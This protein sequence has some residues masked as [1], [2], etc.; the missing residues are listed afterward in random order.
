MK[1]DPISISD[2][3]A[4]LTIS[5]LNEFFDGKIIPNVGVRL[6]DGRRWPDDEPRPTTILL[7]H[8]GALRSMLLPGTEVG[9]G[10]A[11]LYDDFDVE[12]NLEG[13]FDLVDRL[14]LDLNGVLDKLRAGRNLLKLPSGTKHKPGQRGPA[15]LKGKSH[16]IERDRKAVTYHY[17]VSNQF[18]ALWLD[19]HM[20]YSCAYFQ[21]ENDDLDRAQEHKLDHICRKLRLRS[22]Q[23]LLDIGCGWGG[24]AIYAAQRYGVKAT[25]VT[26]SQ[27]QADLANA[28]IAEAGL[29]DRCQVR[30]QDYREVD[31][32]RV[33]DALVSVGMFEHVGLALL[34]VYFAQAWRL[35]KPG[36][37]FLNHGIARRATDK[38]AHGPTFSDT[39]VFPDGELVPIYVTLRRRKRWAL[40]CAMW[41]ACANTMP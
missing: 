14:A 7:R 15:R 11:Y 29:S 13:V 24:L 22:G 18:Y 35:L 28:R 34:P 33:Y 39:Y 8:P 41:R 36:G 4:A 19:R 9:L 40:R 12:G 30:V 26:L 5:L 25:G 16:S 38:P 20:V 23:R 10:E 27:P 37:V 3:S 2:Q 6:W 21:V 17:D 32:P 31:E 1:S